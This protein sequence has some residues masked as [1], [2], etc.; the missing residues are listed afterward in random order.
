MESSAYI[1][2]RDVVFSRSGRRIF[3]GISLDIPK[4]KV[5][6]IMGPSGTGKTTLLRLIGGQLRPDSGQVNVAGHDVPG[7]KRKALYQ[8][9][10]KM[11]MLF[12][13]GALFTDLSVYENVAFPLRV[14]TSLP[15]DMIRDI[16]LM[17]LEAVGLRGARELM[18]SELS[19]GMTRRV[20]LAR[21]IALD[22]E[23]IMY[24][25]P[26]AGQD[27]IAMG[28]L[29]KLIRD[30]NSSM[31]LTSVLVSHDVPESLSICHYACIIADGKVIGEGTPEELRAHPSERV[32]Q[33]L[34]G[35]PDGPV[36]FHYPSGDA[37][38]DFGVGGLSS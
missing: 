20:A 30:L 36:P 15:E 11:G 33:F 18:P 13:S 22:P 10:E 16:V 29:V 32:Q 5:T 27:P 38:A 31:G 19:G 2:L 6:A 28:V 23:L 4:G 1:T 37:A 24:D 8:L 7:L 26:F 25:E 21:S 17:K 14:H 35:Q 12:Q 3:D 34:E 9:R